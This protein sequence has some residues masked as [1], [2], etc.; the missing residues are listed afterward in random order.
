MEKTKFVEW[1]VV[2]SVPE[3]KQHHYNNNNNNTVMYTV[4][5]KAQ[6]L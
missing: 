6:V 2:D 4:H 1:P 3:E 5:R